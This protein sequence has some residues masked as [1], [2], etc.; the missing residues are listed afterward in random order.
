V[1]GEE[2]TP[3]TVQAGSSDTG[4]EAANLINRSGLR[5]RD[6]DSLDEHSVDPAHM[7]R[8]AKGDA[9]CWVEFDL[10]EAQSLGAICLW[11]YNEAWHTDR[12]ISKADISVWTQDAGW[13]KIRDDLPLERAQG[14]DDYDEPMLV[15]LDAVTAQKV[16]FDDLAGFGDPDCIGLSKVQ[17]F[18]SPGPQAVQPYPT[19]GA[20]AM[21]ASGVVLQWTAGSNAVGHNLY[22]GPDP[23]K[24]E[25][26]G[27]VDTTSAELS[28]LAPD[29]TY[30]WRIDEVQAAGAPVSSRVWSFTTG[31]LMAWWK[32]DEPDGDRA[33]DASGHNHGGQVLGDAV[34]RPADG[35]LGGALEFDG[36]DD[37][38]EDPSAGEYLNGLSAVTVTLW[39]KSDVREED[40]DIFFTREPTGDD[41]RLGLR[42]DK[43]GIFGGGKSCIKACIGTA[44]GETQLESTS[45]VQST[46]WQHLAIAWEQGSNL[47]LYI[48]GFCNQ[49]THD[50][51][52]LSGPIAGVEKLMLG[53]GSKGLY[54]DGLID[55]VRIYSYAL[56]GEQIRASAAGE[57]APVAVTRVTL[58]TPPIEKQIEKK[59]V[60]WWKLDETGGRTVS[61]SSG[62][63]AHGALVGDPRWRPT[64]GKIGGALEFNGADDYVEVVAGPSF[65]LVDQI[66]VAAWIKVKQ[67]DKPFQTIIAKGDTTWR[68]SRDAG[69]D[70]LIFATGHDSR[71]H[72]ARGG[73]SVDDG[74]WHH[75]VGVYDGRMIGLYIDGRLDASESATDKIPINSQPITI[76]ENAGERGRCWSGLIDDVQIYNHALM[77]EQVTALYSGKGLVT[78]AA[79]VASE[80]T[81][82]AA[83]AEPQAQIQPAGSGAQSPPAQQPST[84][85]DAVPPPPA[86]TSLSL[87]GVMLILLMVVG[88][89]AGISVL[90]RPRTS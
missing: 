25:L 12:G 61:D 4:A 50:S 28:P 57:V 75:V 15:K 18:A 48:N 7:W 11:N 85:A 54:W 49:P 3:K 67:F 62:G 69:G 68:I 52:P 22:F 35:K 80:P 74:Q 86:R 34:W 37:R 1:T 87:V 47:K 79:V 10:G 63:N 30:Y 32:L 31:G 19:D 21:S 17:F 20:T 42:Y 70:G 90:V 76:G 84:R 5:N 88:V 2:I 16:R 72:A 66:T 45:D 6:A 59:L 60:A 55:D 81:P 51:G 29:T 43:E 36:R 64:G 56:T 71:L 53:R 23:Q 9:A 83:Q 26:L 46:D 89:I 65:H 24:L 8:S 27:R 38:V 33:A 14:S 58:K 41:N 44:Q 13:R 78:P 82:T 39:I 73:L 77:P 40:R